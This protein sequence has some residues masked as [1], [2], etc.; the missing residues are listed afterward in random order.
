MG[1][2]TKD[3]KHLKTGKLGRSYGHLKDRFDERDY[4]FSRVVPTPVTLPT[5]VDLRPGCSPIEDQGDLGSCTAE[6]IVGAME[7]LEIE[8]QEAFKLLSV[9]FLYYNER[10]LEGSVSTD[11]GAMIRDGIKSVVKQG[12]CPTADWPYIISKF[13]TQPP[14]NCYTDAITYEVL[15]YYGLSSLHDMQTCLAQGFPFV[16]GCEVYASFESNVVTTT[17]VVPMPSHRDRLLGGHCMLAV[18]YDQA[19]Q[20]F[21]VKNSWGA[22][23]GMSG[24]CTMPFAY[25]SNPSLTNSLWTIRK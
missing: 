4:P 6:G 1:L 17:G 25:L 2:F 3:A 21:I 14:A 9:L 15:S 5:S 13:A 24:Y 12:V 16:F 18:G 20:R 19:S 22:S 10:V 23:W 11:S 7:F 8:K